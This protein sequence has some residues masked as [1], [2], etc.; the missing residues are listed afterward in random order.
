MLM[1]LPLLTYTDS[2]NSEYYGIRQAFW[3]GHS[4]CANA[5]G[6]FFCDLGAWIT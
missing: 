6:T 3:F 5:N 4:N 1:I 2:D